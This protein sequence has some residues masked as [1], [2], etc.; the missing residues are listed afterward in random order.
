MKTTQQQTFPA[1]DISLALSNRT[2]KQE[3]CSTIKKICHEVG[4]FIVRNH[5]VDNELSKNA[6]HYCQQFFDLPL[7]NKS[8]IDKTNSRHFRGWEAVGS[9]YT[10]NRPDIREQID[11]WSEH[12]PATVSNPHYLNLLGPNQWLPD[13]ILP[14]FKDSITSYI[15]AMESLANQLL[16]LLAIGLGLP[17][18]YFDDYFGAQRMSLTKLINYPETPAGQFGVNA[19]HDTGFLTI[20][21][22]GETPGLEIE[23]ADGTW[24]PVPVIADTF[25][26]NLGEMLQAVTGNY[27]IATPHRVCTNKKRLSIGYFHGPSLTTPINRLPLSP[28]Y[29]KAVNNSPRHKNAGFM[30]PISDTESGVGDMQGTLQASTFGDQLW[31]Y[32]CRSYPNNVKQYYPELVTQ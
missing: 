10:N 3:L 15:N 7:E 21:N 30:A 29:A 25:V 4:F 23:M 5:Q 11:L 13:E 12:S 24:Q 18:N 16:E 14:G 26:V 32:F 8:L 6:F 31:N 27:Y 28:E 19:H 9:E 22:P 1:I 17:E 20:L 2:D